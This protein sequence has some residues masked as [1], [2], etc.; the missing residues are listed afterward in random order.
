[1]VIILISKSGATICRRADSG[2]CTR[3]ARPN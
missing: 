1:M 2:G 3:Q